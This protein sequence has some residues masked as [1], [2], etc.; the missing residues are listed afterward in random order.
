MSSFGSFVLVFVRYL[1]S[2]F[3]MSLFMCFFILIVICLCISLFIYI[4]RSSVRV[5]FIFH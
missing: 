3:V 2:F 5:L 1:F 4:V